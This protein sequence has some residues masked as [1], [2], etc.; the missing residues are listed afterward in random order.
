[1][2]KDNSLAKNDVNNPRQIGDEEK[3]EMN[4]M[5]DSEIKVDAWVK[6]VAKETIKA[7]EPDNVTSSRILNATFEEWEKQGFNEVPPSARNSIFSIYSQ[8]IRNWLIPNKRIF[9]GGIAISV[10]LGFIVNTFVANQQFEEILG[11]TLSVFV[12]DFS[13]IQVI[14]VTAFIIF[15]GIITILLIKNSGEK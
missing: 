15:G 6:S 5:R 12:S 14:A 13:S 7:S 10:F 8:N 4:E 9:I 2:K 11:E 3:T 1:M